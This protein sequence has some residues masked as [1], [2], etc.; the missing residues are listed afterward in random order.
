MA[1]EVFDHTADIG[2]RV[3]A[4]SLDQLFA[5]AGRAVAMLVIENP[6]AIELRHTITIDIEDDDLEALFV[7]WL[8]ELIYRVDAERLLLR[9]FC[10]RL[11]DG[12]RRLRA[13]CRGE[14]ADWTRHRPE[15][16]LKAVTYHQL[17]VAQTPTGWEAS[18]IF[19]I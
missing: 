19:D 5:E 12:D 15:H 14:A 16:E 1:V 6:D 7:D 3:T 8:R 10:V 17:R 2:V 11:S 13:E 4:A 18:V 9:E